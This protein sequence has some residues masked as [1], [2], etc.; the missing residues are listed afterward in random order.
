MKV[1]FNK[2]KKF[3]S[4][5]RGRFDSPLPVG[6]SEYETWVQSI[7][8]TYNP[9][10]TDRDVK[11]IVSNEVLTLSPGTISKPKFYFYSRVRSAAAKQIAGAHFVKI[12]EEQ[13]AAD[14]AAAEATAQPQVASS[15][16]VASASTA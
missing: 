16:S 9:P 10:G 15:D 3:L 5:I 2:V 6:M 13:K 11:W 14:K 7:I 4:K 12:K 8:D 1:A